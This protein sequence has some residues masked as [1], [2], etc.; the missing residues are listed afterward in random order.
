MAT[1][2][3]FSLFITR[4]S[5]PAVKKAVEIRIAELESESKSRPLTNLEIEHLWQLR[6]FAELQTVVRG[7]A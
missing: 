4:A 5:L 6:D 7:D 3:D 2:K 1:L